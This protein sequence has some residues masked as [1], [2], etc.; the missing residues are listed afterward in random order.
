MMRPFSLAPLPASAFLDLPGLPPSLPSLLAAAAA[1]DR[2]ALVGGAVRDLLLHRVHNDPWQGVPDLDLVVEPAPI[3]AGDPSVAPAH[4]LARRLVQRLGPAG[5]LSYR[6]HTAYGT[7][8]L[9][10]N[11]EEGPLLLDLASAR[12]EVYAAP[13]EN[14]SVAFGSLADD[15]ARRDFSINA[16]ALMVGEGSVTLL[17]P[18]G[19]QADLGCRQLRLLHGSSLQDDP[20]RIVRGARY[21]ARLGFA[22]APDSLEQWATTLARWPWA[23]RPG[24]PPALAPP[25]LATRLRMELDLLLERE[26]WRAGLRALQSWGALELLDPDLQRDRRWP[27]RLRHAERLGLPLLPALLLA[28]GDPLAVAERLQLPHRHQQLLAQARVLGQRLALLD[29]GQAPA[30]WAPSR[31]CDLLESRGVTAEAVALVAAAGGPWRRPLLRWWLRWRH[32]RSPRSA[33]AL[34]EAGMTPGPQLGQRLRQLRA[35]R[36]DAERR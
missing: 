18:H 28:A 35:E 20:T 31:W 23:W 32:L 9:E 7:A 12:H 22:L 6:E 4:R 19:G 21:A 36:L 8:E 30:L 17:D 10:L 29:P 11:L 33:A 34:I 24:D 25:A 16:M 5:V 27:W 14:P 2:L 1:A 3:E 26:P 15:L 13:G